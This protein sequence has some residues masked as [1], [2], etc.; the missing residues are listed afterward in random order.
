MGTL[1]NIKYGRKLRLPFFLFIFLSS[2]IGLANERKIRVYN[3]DTPFLKALLK[4]VL[5]RSSDKSVT[6]VLDSKIRTLQR[7]ITQLKRSQI[8]LLVLAQNKVRDKDLRAIKIPLL[9]GLLG[10]RLL[11]IHKSNLASFSNIKSLKELKNFHLGF[12]S[13]WMDRTIYEEN[14]F[15]L[16]H[17]PVK[18]HLYS[19]LSKKRFDF[20]PRGLHEIYNELELIGDKFP[21]LVIAP[22]IYLEYRTN[23]YF[24]VNKSNNALYEEIKKNLEN[25]IAS[26]EHEKLFNTFYKDILKKANLDERNSFKLI[27]N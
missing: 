2:S 14:G 16:S 5:T 8:D 24:Y 17:S 26:G 19:M 21:A 10:K 15:R 27:V 9:N 18:N 1:V 11:L 3:S 6:L 23:V 25:L 20:F 12:G 22:N 13:H 7:A 4:K